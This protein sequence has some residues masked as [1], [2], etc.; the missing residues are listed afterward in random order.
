MKYKS[1]PIILL[2]VCLSL[3]TVSS[4]AWSTRD[5]LGETPKLQRNAVSK[6]HKTKQKA[7]VGTYWVIHSETILVS[8]T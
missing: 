4:F 5:S 8:N 3:L 6:K 1:F 7:L 2:T